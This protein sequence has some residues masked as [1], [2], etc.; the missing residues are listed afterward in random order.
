MDFRG[1]FC[2]FAGS[3][4][5][6]LLR[7]YINNKLKVSRILDFSNTSFVNYLAS[8]FLGILV[9]LNPLNKNFLLLFNVGFLGCLSTFS[10]FIYELFVLLK[11]RQFVRLLFYYI[12]VIL[13]SFLCFYLGYYLIQ[14]FW[15]MCKKIFIF[16]ICASFIAATL[17]L[18]INNNLLISV[19]GSFLFGF[20]VAR[21]LSKSIKKV[22]L[23]G[24]CCCFTSFSAFILSLYKIL[25]KGEI[26]QAIFYSN[27]V[28]LLNLLSMLCGFLI[29]RKIT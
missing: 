19:I 7:I 13:L 2:L 26:L 23:I 3:T 24:F 15:E 25:N 9:A 4:S 28:V 11:R 16:F 18:Y 8:F 5:G 14:S 27:F 12:E 6:L 22:L 20:V 29:S 1:I 21:N 10:S 17:R